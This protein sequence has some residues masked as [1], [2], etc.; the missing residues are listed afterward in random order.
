MASMT[1]TF[2]VDLE[3]DRDLLAFFKGVPS[4]KRSEHIRA[5][6]RKYI[7]QAVTLGDVY[8]ELAEVK[9]MLRAGTG[10][11]PSAGADPEADAGDPRVDQA[12]RKIADLGL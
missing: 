7:G 5:A 12:R 2:T 9:R 1:F 10:D 6:V 3:R 8:Q 11:L 4:R